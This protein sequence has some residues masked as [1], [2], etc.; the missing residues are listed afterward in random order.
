M[1]DNCRV[2]GCRYALCHITAGHKCGKCKRFGHGRRECG[3]GQKMAQLKQLARNDTLREEDRCDVIGCRHR[4]YHKTE[5]HHCTA[6][7]CIFN[8]CH[9][10]VSYTNASVQEAR[11]ALERHHNNPV[12]EPVVEEEQKEAECKVLCPVC[13]AD[14]D[15]YS[16]SECKIF[17]LTQICDVCMV[18]AIEMRL[19]CKHACLCAVC[20]GI[21]SRVERADEPDYYP[22]AVQEARPVLRDAPNRSYVSVY[23]GQGCVIYVK[24]VNEVYSTFFMHGDSWGQ[25]GTGPG[26]DDRPA[27][28]RFLT[29]C[30]E[31]EDAQALSV[32]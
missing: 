6:C 23:A 25:Y 7:R 11:D 18:R 32:A 8:Q 9:C 20:F 3:R 12:A 29:G 1:S 15:I 17:G 16:V 24:K 19:P 4:E 26:L 10:G 13:R 31:I 14:N 2:L 21:L 22:N 5:S 27:R 28:E 30:T